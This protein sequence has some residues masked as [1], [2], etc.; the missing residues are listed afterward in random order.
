[1]PDFEVCRKGLKE[2]GIEDCTQ[3]CNKMLE[4]AKV[5]VGQEKQRLLN[6]Q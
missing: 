3:M 2:A 1:M 5:A 4:E 6:G